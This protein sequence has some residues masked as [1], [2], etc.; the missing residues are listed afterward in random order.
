[1]VTE[2][3]LIRRHTNYRFIDKVSPKRIVSNKWTSEEYILLERS[4]NERERDFSKIMY[5]KDEKLS[6]TEKQPL[7]KDLQN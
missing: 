6:N 3:V 2:C 4:N 1:M 5:K 7:Q